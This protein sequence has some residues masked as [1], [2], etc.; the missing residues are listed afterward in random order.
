MGTHYQ[1]KRCSDG[2]FFVQSDREECV[3]DRDFPTRTAAEN[4]RKECIKR[5]ERL[6]Y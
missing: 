3:G 2:T 5:D 1:V 6:G 4:Y